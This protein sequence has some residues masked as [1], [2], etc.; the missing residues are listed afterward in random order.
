MNVEHAD[1]HQTLAV[2]APP[3]RF[4]LLL[5]ML[6]GIDRSVSQLAAGVG[7]SQSCTSRHLQALE[8]AGLV[9]RWRRG[10]SVV[11]RPLA[12]DAVAA[13]IL[14]SLGAASIGE[15]IEL[16]AAPASDVTPLAAGAEPDSP[17]QEPIAPLARV[18]SGKKTTEAQPGPRFRSDI[19]DYL[20]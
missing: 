2:L 3:K 5:L 17:E 11:F 18:K 20:L 4:R 13:G 8:R 9:K 16:L 19:E 14:A 6:S 15:S 1:L 7:L 12:R 10:K